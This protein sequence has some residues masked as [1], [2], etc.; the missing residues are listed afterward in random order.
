[1]SLFGKLFRPEPGKDDGLTQG[2]REAIADALHFCMYADNRIATAETQLV[3]T[4]TNTLTWDP[5]FSYSSYEARS[6]ALARQA[7]ESPGHR[8]EFLASLGKRLNSTNSRNLAIS[9]AARLMNADGQQTE[10]ETGVLSEVR[11]AVWSKKG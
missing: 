10:N 2:E 5:K 8:K 9:L 11:N 4:W 7:K 1:M 6:I 3:E